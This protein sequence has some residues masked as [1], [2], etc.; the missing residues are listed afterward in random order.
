MF[1]RGGQ[2]FLYAEYED[3][4]YTSSETIPIVHKNGKKGSVMH[5]KWTQ[6]GRKFLYDKLKEIGILPM[7]ERK[8]TE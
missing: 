7:I 6:K 2:W 4:G 3:G 1:K 8:V 5:T